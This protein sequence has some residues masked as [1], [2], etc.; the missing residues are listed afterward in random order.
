MS[1]TGLTLK[2][3]PRHFVEE[4]R[5]KAVRKEELSPGRPGKIA[6]TELIIPQMYQ[7]IPVLPNTQCYFK[8][9]QTCSP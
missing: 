6:V 2:I 4:F 3:L 9:A 7:L 5:P 1:F 8:G